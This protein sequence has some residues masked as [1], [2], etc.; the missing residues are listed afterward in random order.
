MCTVY[1]RQGHI[2]TANPMLSFSLGHILT[3]VHTH[4]DKTIK[5]GQCK[6][7]DRACYKEGKGRLSLGLCQ[8]CRDGRCWKQGPTHKPTH[9]QTYRVWLLFTCEKKAY[10]AHSCEAK[11]RSDLASSLPLSTP[12]LL[13]LP[14]SQPFPCGLSLR[15]C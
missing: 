15:V 10:L 5:R 1:P 11:E 14:S 12:S 2:L 13:P 3:H 6:T 8:R 4:K 7:G 9:T